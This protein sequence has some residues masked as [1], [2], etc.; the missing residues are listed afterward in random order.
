MIMTPGE[1]NELEAFLKTVSLPDTIQ[2]NAAAKIH[3]LP[4]F[5][6]QTLVNLRKPDIAEVAL[7]P[8]YDDLLTIRKIL[9]GLTPPSSPTQKA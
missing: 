7:R 4:A 9:E 2:L 3:D 8:R 6:N 1:L 5:V